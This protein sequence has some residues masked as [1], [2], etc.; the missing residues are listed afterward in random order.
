MQYFRLRSIPITLTA[1]GR[2]AGGTPASLMMMLP[3]STPVPIVGS[4]TV[5]FGVYAPVFARAAA[6][7]QFGVVK[8]RCSSFRRLTLF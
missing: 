5:T 6:C 7:A 8:P 3:A 2:S 1:F 4:S